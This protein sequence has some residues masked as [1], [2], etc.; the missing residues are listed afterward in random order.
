[1]KKTLQANVTDLIS[2]SSFDE[3]DWCNHHSELKSAIHKYGHDELERFTGFN[4]ELHCQGNEG[5]LI[6]A[7]SLNEAKEELN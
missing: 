2:I 1:M 6:R 5:V 7:L 3:K 4:R